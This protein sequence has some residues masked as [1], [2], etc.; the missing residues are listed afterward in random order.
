MMRS[1]ATVL[2]WLIATVL[3]AVAI[4]AVWAQ[5]NV[6]DR[7]GYAALAGRAAA[8]PQLQS[9]MAAELTTQVGRLGSGVDSTIVSRIADAY[10]SSS[11]FPAQFAQANAFAHRWLFTNTIPSTVDPQGRWVIDLAPMLSDSAFAQTLSDYNLTV[12]STVPIPLTDNAPALLRPGSLRLAGVWGPWVA[13]GLTVLATAAAMLTLLAA[14][15]RG[16][17]IVALGVSALMVGAAGWAAIELAQPDLRAAL[18]NTSG[19]TRLVADAMVATAQ[20]SM[21]QWLNLTLIVGGGVVIVGVVVS[22]L[23]G[24]AR[25]T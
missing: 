7:S 2:M 15:R 11:E 16:R 6:V 18:N 19:N 3:L 5:Q 1:A 22:L 17:A 20:D 23:S 9:A 4:P 12:P 21:H 25:S 24:L 8:D 14:R 13:V 10:V